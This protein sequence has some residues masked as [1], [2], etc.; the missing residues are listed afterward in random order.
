MYEKQEEDKAMN[1][2]KDGNMENK[3]NKNY[4]GSEKLE[5]GQCELDDN[6]LEQAAGGGAPK[7]KDS[8]EFLEKAN[9]RIMNH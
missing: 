6:A 1:A 3:E 5:R 4:E 2:R 9:E 7:P 8:Y